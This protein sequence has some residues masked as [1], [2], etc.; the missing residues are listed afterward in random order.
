MKGCLRF[1]CHMWGH[2]YVDL[3][4]HRDPKSGEEYIH[5]LHRKGCPGC[6]RGLQRALVIASANQQLVR[7]I[8]ARVQ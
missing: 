6:D 8:Q 5:R 4:A 2:E 1:S 7:R 3:I